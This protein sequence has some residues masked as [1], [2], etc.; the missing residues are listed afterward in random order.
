ATSPGTSAPSS[1]GPATPGRTSPSA[2][3]PSSSA[4]HPSATPGPINSAFPGLTTFRGNAT[5]DYYG[6]GPVP[7][8]PVILWRYPAS[9]GMCSRSSDLSGV[10][11]WCGTGWTGQPNV[12]THKDGTIE[13]REGAYDDNYHFW[14]G[15]T[16]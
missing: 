12:I 10:N 14:N 6:E 4:A 15:K 16:G 5:R 1:P 2:S 7:T 9:G 11:T 3:S 8:H 13:I